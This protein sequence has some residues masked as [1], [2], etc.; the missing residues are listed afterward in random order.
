MAVCAA[1]LRTQRSHAEPCLEMWPCRT[2]RSEP[3][4]VGVSPAQLASLRALGNRVM[5]AQAE[6]RTS[7]CARLG[8]VSGVITLSPEGQ[9]GLLACSV[10][11]GV[12]LTR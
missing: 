5:R 1:W 6:L 4:T 11:P 9:P 8:G 3:R 12:R 2:D 10:E 7:R